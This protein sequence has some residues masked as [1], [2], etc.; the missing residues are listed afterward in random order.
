[1]ICTMVKSDAYRE[2]EWKNFAKFF[3]TI[4]DRK[5]YITRTFILKTGKKVLHFIPL[6]EGETLYPVNQKFLTKEEIERV[7]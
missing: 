4:E 1:M 3:A 7:Y 5:G 2:K 6:N